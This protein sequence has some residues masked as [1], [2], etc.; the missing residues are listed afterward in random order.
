MPPAKN[1]N[2]KRIKIMTSQFINF[3]CWILQENVN[4]Y[5]SG[6]ILFYATY[7]KCHLPDITLIPSAYK[8]FAIRETLA[9]W[10]RKQEKNYFN[11]FG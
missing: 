1:T 11:A 9:K 2:K 8:Y 7:I 5:F 10:I 6:E 3:V 4:K